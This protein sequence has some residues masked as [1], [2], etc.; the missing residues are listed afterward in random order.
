MKGREQTSNREVEEEKSDGSEVCVM[1]YINLY[2]TGKLLYNLSLSLSLS[3]SRAFSRVSLLPLSL[4]ST[5][6]YCCYCCFYYAHQIIKNTY[7][8][9]FVLRNAV[10]TNNNRVISFVRFQSQLFFRFK[11]IFLQLF[12]FSGEHGFGAAVESMQLDLILAMKLPPCFKKYWAF[13]ATILA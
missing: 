3:L 6:V 9:L 8:L 11:S 1:F 4:F 2:L 12:D 5:K 7:L 10:G 13:K